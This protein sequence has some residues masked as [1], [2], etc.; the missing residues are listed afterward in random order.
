MYLELF[1][2]IRKLQDSD[3]AKTVQIKELQNKLDEALDNISYLHSKVKELETS[4]EP[5]SESTG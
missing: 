1:D 4:L 2:E 3:Q 5:Y